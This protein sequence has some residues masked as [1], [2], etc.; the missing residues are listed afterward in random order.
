[1]KEKLKQKKSGAPFSLPILALAI[2]L[3]LISP[4]LL[5]HPAYDLHRDEYLHLDQGHHLSWGYISVPPVT[6]WIAWLIHFLGGSEFWVKFFPALFGALTIVIVARI[7]ETIGGGVYAVLLGC[8]SVLVSGIL[9]INILFQPNSL[10]I[11]FWTLLFYT[12]L[13]YFKDEKNKWLYFTA[14]AFA[15]GF[16]SKYN[17]LVLAAGLTPA[18]LLTSQRKVFLN[19]HL[20]LAAL[21]ALVTVMPNLLWQFNNGFPT[22]SQLRELAATQLVN[23]NRM[24]FMKEQFLLFASS[25]FIIIAGLLS[26]FIYPAFKQ[27]RFVGLTWIFCIT[28]FIFA[29]AK[30]YYAMG[31]YPVLLAFGSVYVEGLISKG[32]AFYLRPVFFLIVV[33]LSVPFILIAFPINSPAAIAKDA[34]RFRDLGLLRWE[35]GKDHHLPQDFADMLGWR[36]IAFLAD[37]A[38]DQVKD[39]EHTL[40]LC[41]NYGQA[42]AVNYYSVNRNI[43][44]VSFNADYINWIPLEKPLKNVILVREGADSV[45]TEEKAM[46]D[47]VILVGINSN[48]FAREKGAKVYL[49]KGAKIDLNARLREEIGHELQ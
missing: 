15:F 21:V 19:R 33:A 17:I 25:F 11:F 12:L 23:V 24:D 28:L 30:G 44:A 18:L 45:R 5:I 41:D 29:K 1:M 10:D 34:Q 16:L 49:L 26:F 7:I 46:F 14:I 40:V 27:Y 47:T 6:S 2:I 38:Y 13:R 39:K 20:Y 35:D 43:N 42:G 3:K 22:I 4:F 32:W 9:R 31:L 48:E 8:V 36:E 37:K